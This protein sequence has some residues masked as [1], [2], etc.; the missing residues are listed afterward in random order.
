MPV[1]VLESRG[2]CRFYGLGFL[3][4]GVW[5]VLGLGLSEQGSGFRGGEVR[6]VLC[7]LNIPRDEK[8]TVLR[9]RP[10]N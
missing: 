3:R 9:V 5:E 2:A 4:F 6:T 10:S 8:P 1:Q 7:A